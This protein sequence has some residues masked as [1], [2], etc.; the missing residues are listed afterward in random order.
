VD[1]RGD[2]VVSLRLSLVRGGGAA[3]VLL[4]GRVSDDARHFSKQP[5]KEI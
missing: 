4:V 1:R 2:C 5:P 3:L